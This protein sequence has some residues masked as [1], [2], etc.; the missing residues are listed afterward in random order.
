[1]APVHKKC[2][3]GNIVNAVRRISARTLV[4]LAAVVAA[5]AAI[6]VPDSG[7]VSP[8]SVGHV[9]MVTGSDDTGWS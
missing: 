9:T 7:G 2:T 1:L 8:Q 5:V 4:L 3:G 6:A